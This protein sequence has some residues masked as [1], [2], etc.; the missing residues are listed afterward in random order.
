MEGVVRFEVLRF[1]GFGARRSLALLRR[2]L[3]FEI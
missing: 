3:K 1:W 2:D